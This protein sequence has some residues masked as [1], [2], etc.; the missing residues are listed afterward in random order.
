MPEDESDGLRWYMNCSCLWF[1]IRS[2]ATRDLRQL[3]TPQTWCHVKIPTITPFTLFR[4][5]ALNAIEEHFT[6]LHVFKTSK[7]H[8]MPLGGDGIVFCLFTL[9]FPLMSSRAF[10]RCAAVPL[11][12]TIRSPLFLL[13]A[14][15]LA[16]RTSAPDVFCQS[17]DD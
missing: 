9:G 8:L 7:T 2:D 14:F 13:K 10:S 16:T 15:S 1:F 3:V 11:M 17:V 5:H 4:R 6:E 12:Y